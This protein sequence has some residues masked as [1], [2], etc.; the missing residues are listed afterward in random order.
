[1]S[2]LFPKTV[3]PGLLVQLSAPVFFIVFVLIIWS[4][5]RKD[6]KTDYTRFSK[7]PLQDDEIARGG[8]GK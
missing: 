2:A 6:K 3:D 1:M 5:Y 4:V 7:I 8:N